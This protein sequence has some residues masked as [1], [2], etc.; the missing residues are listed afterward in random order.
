MFLQN[1]LPFLIGPQIFLFLDPLY[2]PHPRYRR[3]AALVGLKHLSPLYHLFL[4]S[5]P[6]LH[7]HRY[8]LQLK[9]IV[10]AFYSLL[11]VVWRAIVLAFLHPIPLR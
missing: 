2:P 10:E 8:H 3:E 4:L 7:L 6:L 5:F 11:L 9:F 1:C